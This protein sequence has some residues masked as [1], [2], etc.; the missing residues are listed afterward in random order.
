MNDWLD[1][2]LEMT[3]PRMTRDKFL[4]GLDEM[5][6]QEGRRPKV[7]EFWCVRCGKMPA[8]IFTDRPLCWDHA[9]SASP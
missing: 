4:N 1:A 6:E 7:K 8:F 2:A 9:P 3:E 5:M